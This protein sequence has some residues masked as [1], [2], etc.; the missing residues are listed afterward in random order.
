MVERRVYDDEKHIHF[1][2]FSCDRRRTLLQ[3]GR[4]KRIVIGQLG[5]RVARQDG[6]CTRFVIMPD[7]VHALVWCPEVRQLSPLMN[8]WKEQTSRQIKESYRT[9]FLN[10][11]SR[12]ADGD[13]IW[14]ISTR[15]VSDSDDRVRGRGHA[16]AQRRKEGLG[17]LAGECCRGDGGRGEDGTGGTP[18]PPFGRRVSAVPRRR[19]WNSFRVHATTSS[20]ATQ[21]G[22]AAPLTLGC[23]CRTPS[24]YKLHARGPR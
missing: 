21:G 19:L 2:T 20:T 18:V 12:I 15:C 16:K 10:Y 4:A 17:S 23:D 1:V 8:K 9:R 22:G 11:W 6:L 3:P 13:P 7:H 14:R 5:S 24:A